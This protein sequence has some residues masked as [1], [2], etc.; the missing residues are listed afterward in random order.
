[1]VRSALRSAGGVRIDHAMGLNRLWVVP[2]GHPA[3]FG[4]YLA[5]P[6]TDLLRLLR[7]ES[8]RHQAIVLAENLGT[9]PEGFSDRLRDAGIDGMSVLWFQRDHDARFMSPS[10][11]PRHASA[12]TSTH[13]LPTVAGW[14]RGRD[15]DWNEKLG[16]DFGD[17]RAERQR[18]RDQLWNALRHAGVA[19]AGPP[20]DWDTHPVADAAV[21]F[22]GRA[23]SEL[24]MLPLEDALAVD[25]APNLPGTT[26]EHPNWR[27][28]L[29]GTVE[30]L[31][32]SAHVAERL[33]I[34]DKAR[35]GA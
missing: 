14:W 20:A 34:L 23:T 25:E 12:M 15:I 21:A 11:W 7:L 5:M 32:D 16:R 24:V 31:L 9:V 30:T 8:A 3:S 17:A 28:R 10:H 1:M 35:S 6:E 22:L 18:D 27:R 2:E 26:T 33:E 19:H 4:T 13:D 29:P